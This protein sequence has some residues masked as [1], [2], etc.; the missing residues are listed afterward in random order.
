MKGFDLLAPVYDQLA[1]LVFGK[2]IVHAQ[3]FFL[4]R[5]RARDRVLILGGGTGWLLEEL[6]KKQPH[7]E[8][9]YVEASLK[10]MNLAKKKCANQSNVH[11]IQGTQWAIPSTMFDVV[12]MNFFLDLF[13]EE[14]IDG[15][16]G[17]IKPITKPD[18]IWLVTDFEKEDK[19]WQHVL[20][21]VMI[22]FFRLTCGIEAKRL[23]DLRSIFRKHGVVEIKSRSYFRRFIKTGVYKITPNPA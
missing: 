5:I 9:W 22:G 21:I 15:L 11:F 17:K 19:W 18:G 2:D 12:I 6:L 13:S 1:R 16:I 8:V 23:P 14:Q 10:M 7:C 20:L 3:L 4:D